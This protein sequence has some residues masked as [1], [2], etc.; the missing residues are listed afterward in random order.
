[1]TA[2]RAQASAFQQRASGE[3]ALLY[4][5]GALQGYE[6]VLFSICRWATGGFQ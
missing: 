4:V 5:R 1:M 6:A 3:R 2:F